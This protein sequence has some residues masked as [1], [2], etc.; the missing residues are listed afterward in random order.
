MAITYTWNIKNLFCNPSENGMNNVI[1]IISWEYTGD[2]GN[3][4][5]HTVSGSTSLP[6]PTDSN[7]FVQY[8]NLTQNTIV[9]WIGSQ[10]SIPNLETIINNWINHQINGTDTISSPWVSPPWANT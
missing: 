7:T 4:H 8:A 5:D 1:K 3:N 6:P 9:S 2:D 10:I